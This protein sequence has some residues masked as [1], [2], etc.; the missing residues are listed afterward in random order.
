[1]LCSALLCSADKADN[2]LYSIGCVTKHLA[3]RLGCTDVEM[4]CGLD[5]LVQS[6]CQK[7]SEERERTSNYVLCTDL[8]SSR[9]H[10]TLRIF[11]GLADSGSLKYRSVRRQALE[12]RNKKV[13]GLFRIFFA[14]EMP[15]VM[16]LSYEH[17][18]DYADPYGS[19][20]TRVSVQPKNK[21]KFHLSEMEYPLKINGN[22]IYF[23]HLICVRATGN[24]WIF[25]LFK[26][27]SF[28]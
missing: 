8:A 26:F 4:N 20:H 12:S 7:G 18:I 23:G 17:A 19:Y 28:L 24:K 6:A 14:V 25:L 10:S 27:P 11:N 2:L 1:M 13:C 3:D 22:S 9:D 21:W 15:M 16:V 5:S